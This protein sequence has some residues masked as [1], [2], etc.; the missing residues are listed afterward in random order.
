MALRGSKLSLGS[1]FCTPVDIDTTPIPSRPGLSHRGAAQ[2]RID[3]KS[4]GGCHSKFEPLA[5][6]LE[7]DD[8]LGAFHVRDPHGNDLR[9][10]GEVL[11]PGEAKPRPFKTSAE[12]MDLLANS[13][14]VRESLTWKIAQFSLGRPLAAREAQTVENIHRESQKQGGT[15]QAVIGAL[16]MSDLVRTTPTEASE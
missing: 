5:F 4:C 15:W 7:R 10:D 1:T 12:L 11:F 8:G 9:E 14:R 3:N 13:E 2:Q 16:I 6:G